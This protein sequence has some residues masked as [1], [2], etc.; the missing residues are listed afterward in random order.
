MK[1]HNMLPYRR[2]ALAAAAIFIANA[3]AQ[4]WGGQSQQYCSNQNT[5]SDYSAGE[6]LA[7]AHASMPHLQ[8][9]ILTPFP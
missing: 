8:Q 4:V 2:T 5:G 3:S 9:R 6:Y 1:H 7:I